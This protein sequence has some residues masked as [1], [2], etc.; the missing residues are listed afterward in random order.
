MGLRQ[1]DLKDMVY[2]VFEI[3][4]FKSKMGE[5]KDIVTLS[6]SVKEREAA[7]DL[8]NF[9][10]KGYDFVLDADSTPGE[11]TDGTY[12]VFV[13]IERN[14]HAPDHISEIIDGVQKLS[15]LEDFKYR[16]Y[17]NFKSIPLSVDSL[18]EQLPLDPDSYD[19]TIQESRL[20]NY[21]EFFNR[22]YV[23]DITMVNETI[24]IKKAYADPVQ[25]RF[26]DFGNS[27]EIL[28]NLKESFNPNDFAEIIFLSKY[29]GDYNIT[30]YGNKLTLENND[31]MLVLERIVV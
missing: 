5:D 16:Y 24:T 12:K 20:N 2:K 3:D 23:D 11:Q 13:E 9:I 30:K 21:K 14:R 31:S 19:M 18:Q 29:I 8:E 6:F 22:S 15:G 26:I 4:S 1:H 10:E 25:F 27:T 7:Y 28:N 17:K